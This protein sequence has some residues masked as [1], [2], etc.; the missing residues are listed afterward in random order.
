MI[1]SLLDIKDLNYKDIVK[2]LDTEVDSDCLKS[3]TI[4]C[5]YQKPSTRTRM[6]FAV[7]INQLKGF[8]LDIKLDD[9]NFSRSESIEDTF[10]ALGLYLDGL[11]FRTNAHDNLIIAKNFLN[12][13]VINALSDISH[14]C[15][16]LSDL[17]TLREYFSRMNLTISWFGDINNVLNSL[18]ELITII[19]DIK[20]NIFSSNKILSKKNFINLSNLN[21]FDKIDY[22]IISKSDCIMT[23]VYIS[24]ND[25]E[26]KNK[27]ELLMPFQVNEKIM[28]KTK[29]TCI[30]MHCLPAK[31]G[32]EVTKEV[33]NSKKSIVWRQA[34]NRL[35]IQKKL[36]QCINWS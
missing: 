7:A 8:P 20:L 31:I 12:K 21:I 22:Q 6:S 9:L 3:K 28:S 27:I 5:V 4:G 16:I 25:Q 35:I 26:S 2:I 29:D 1:K 19:P 23:D 17:F 34:Y 32:Y 11:V 13:P 18:I 36:L 24:M 10:K 30:F 33:I 15:Q 14:P